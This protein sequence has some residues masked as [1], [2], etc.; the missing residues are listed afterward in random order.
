MKK[1]ALIT[2]LFFSFLAFSQN[3][4]N[5]EN[6][7][8]ISK[9]NQVKGDSLITNTYNLENNIK[10]S[11]PA[12]GTNIFQDPRG[13]ASWKNFQRDQAGNIIYTNNGDAHDPYSFENNGKVR[14]QDQANWSSREK[15]GMWQPMPYA[16]V[17][18]DDVM[19]AQRITRE[20]DLRDPNNASL[21]YPNAKL[22]TYHNGRK[23]PPKKEGYDE[24]EEDV[25]IGQYFNEVL[26]GIDARKNF[27]NILKDAALVGQV[28]VY[29]PSMS[30]LYTDQEIAGYKDEGLSVDG[31][32]SFT[33]LTE[34]TDFDE[35]TGREDTREVFE[36]MEIES[37]Q[38]S[39]Y[40]IVED[41]FFDKRRSKMDV[42]I[43]SITPIAFIDM[44]P[45][46]EEEN[47]E[48][49]PYECGTFY[50]PEIRR[51]LCNHKV[52]NTDNMM[53]RMS[54][55]EFFQRRLFTSYIVKES[56]VYDRTIADYI[57]VDEKIGEA[58]GRL[59]QLWEAERIKENIR[60]FE[61]SMWEY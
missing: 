42:R 37:S 30:R 26:T 57:K 35:E 10:N 54:F 50:Y 18:E 43:V 6:R 52:Y 46:S 55:D 4:D 9:M 8:D 49:Q 12:S 38:I 31:L 59:Y 61:S 25:V 60:S 39:T 58:N 15:Q 7:E 17:S 3:N 40:R 34:E 29:N 45:E 53:S 27:F 19:W 56:N 22:Y 1:I 14:W 36:E 5:T 21:Y 13:D 23:A 33:I 51:L 20:I 48:L 44:D 41:W 2:C 24:E 11:E 32:F 47:K 28:N 16:Y